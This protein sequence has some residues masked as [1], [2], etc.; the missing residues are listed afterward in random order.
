MRLFAV[1]LAVPLA[2]RAEDPQDPTRFPPAVVPGPVDL[3]S[4]LPAQPAGP[5]TDLPEFFSRAT[6][7]YVEPSPEDKVRLAQ[8]RFHWNIIPFI[9]TNPLI[10]FGGGVAAAGV[11]RVGDENT[12]LSKFTTDVLVTV[13]DQ[14][15]IPVRTSIFFSENAWSLVGF[16]DVKWFPSPTY[17]IG[18]NTPSSAETI[19][20]YGLL[21]LWQT[22]YRCLFDSLYAGA[23]A[24]FD[25][26][27]SVGNRG[28]PEG[29]PNPFTAYPYGTAGPYSNVGASVDLLFE[30]RDNPVNA[31]KGYYASLTYRAFPTWLGSTNS[32]QSLYANGRAYFGLPA[33][34]VLALWAYGWFSFGN[35][36]YLDLPS[37][38]SDPDARSGRGYIEGRHIGK[39]LLYAEAEYRFHIW[40]FLGGAVGLNVHSASQPEAPGQAQNALTFQYW[41]PAATIGLRALVN[42]PTRANGLIEFGI[43][44]DG[45]RGFYLNINENF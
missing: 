41:Y 38:G 3:P 31:A 11:F 2:A 33:P 7:L 28:A 32:W 4:P 18:G 45:S 6:G 30:S 12:K 27:Y 15:S 5:T 8:E 25:R 42:R 13:N 36:P 9:L 1:A 19:V 10:N 29:Q 44:L 14:I 37:I 20:D 43:G 34:N 24:Y 16:L 35:T 26:Y 22:A 39:A 21:R 40:E 23:G 17:G